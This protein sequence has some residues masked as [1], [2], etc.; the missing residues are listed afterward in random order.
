MRS[1]SSYMQKS[2]SLPDNTAGSDPSNSHKPS[3]QAPLI[4]LLMQQSHS[5]PVLDNTGGSDPSS[6]HKASGRSKA[7]DPTEMVV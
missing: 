4:V 5:L 6:S 1:S 3:G 7:I 2:H